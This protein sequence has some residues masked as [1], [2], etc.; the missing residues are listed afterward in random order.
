MGWPKSLLHSGTLLTPPEEGKAEAQSLS[1][2]STLP[3]PR[4]L[5]QSKRI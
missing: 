1:H 2:P 4:T 5:G 3:E